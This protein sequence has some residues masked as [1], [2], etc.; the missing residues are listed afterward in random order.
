MNKVI[1]DGL[2]LAPSPFEEGLDQWSSGNGTPGSDT[3]DGVVNAAYV[4]A[5]ADFGGC[6][7]L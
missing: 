4:A 6:L 5:D 2:Q 7:E 1:T 3:Y